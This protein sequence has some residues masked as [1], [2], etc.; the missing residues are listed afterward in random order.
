[1]KSNRK[2]MSLMLILACF[3]IS[4]VGSMCNISSKIMYF[5]CTFQYPCDA[6][7]INHGKPQYQQCKDDSHSAAF[8]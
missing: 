1:M 4:L 8:D 5:H 7:E 3:Q 6:A 2:R